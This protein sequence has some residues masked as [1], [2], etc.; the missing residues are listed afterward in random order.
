[1]IARSVFYQRLPIC[2]GCE[3]WRGACIKGH[4][5]QGSLGCPMKKFE[6]VDGVGY[7]DDLPVPAPK[8]PAVS[9]T[10]CCPDVVEGE[11]KPMSL[12]EVWS[13]LFASM[14]EWKKSGFETVSK[15]VY[16]KRIQICRECPKGEYQWFQCKQCR[17]IV[18][19]KA[20]LATEDC[21]HGLWPA[22][23]VVNV[24]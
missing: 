23:S 18:Y 3:F 22:A 2:K 8:L 20:K 16:V 4:V 19:I 13:H 9:P 7:M 21:P 14:D 1:M 6:G 24:G 11:I 10:D 12:G 15:E 5:L 17:C